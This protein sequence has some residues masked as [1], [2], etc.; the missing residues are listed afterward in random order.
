MPRQASAALLLLICCAAAWSLPADRLTTWDPGV[1]G[2][3]PSVTTI[4]ATLDA[5]RYGN[6]TADATAAINAAIQSAGDEARVN[7]PLAVYL[8]AGTYRITGSLDLNRSYV[9]LRGAGSD[10]TRIR[11]DSPDESFAVGMGLFWPEYAPP[12]DVVGSVAKGARTLTVADASG[13]E[14]GDVLQL[15]QLD[16]PSY[17]KIGDWIYGK[18]GPRE[19]DAN[20]PSSPEGYRSVGQQIAVVAKRGNTLTLAGPT[21]IAFDAH[22][23]PQVF[24]TCT[25]REGHSGRQWIGLEDV[26]IGGGRNNNI[27]VLNL[28]YGW[29]R[30]V[31]CDGDPATGGGLDGDHINLFHAY[32]CEIRRCYVH[33]ARRIVPGGG[34]YG[35]GIDNQ[36]SDNLV[37]DNIVRCLNKPI[38]TVASGGG[39][40][41]AYNLVDDAYIA[42]HE[43]WQENGIDGCHGSFSHHDLFEGND[44]PNI[45]SDSTHGNCGWQTFFRNH[46]RGMNLG[47]PRSACIRAVG[48]D[49]YNREH[50]FA[51]NVLLS[52]GLMVG[53]RP[54]V[55]LSTSL[56]TFDQAAVY[57][58]GASSLGGEYHDLDDGTALRLLLAHGNFDYASGRV[59][60]DERLA[61]HSMPPSL[62]LRAKPAWFGDELWPYVDPQRSPMVGTL[63][64]RR[65]FENGVR[66]G[67]RAKQENRP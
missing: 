11:Y 7:R 10:L 26:W 59:V 21:H 38:L 17:V 58:I 37:E 34:A 42:D 43:S 22:F 36:S 14:P 47:I 55:Y 28:A 2:G 64:A 1:P 65:R 25:A 32:R 23:R 48:V 50:T 6:G 29:I 62:Y 8:P 30:G 44:T 4:H 35:I 24:H 27:Q 57:R 52:P 15:D 63:P 54:P 9:V 45:G 40:V 56:D 31:E 61:D 12:V 20:G 60:W 67:F 33:H 49:G 66:D 53:G 3:I 5:T 39:N 46:A 19:A 41:V 13:I 16:D 18:R 51:G